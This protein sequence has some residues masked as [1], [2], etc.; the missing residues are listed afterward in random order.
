MAIKTVMRAWKCPKC[1]KL[2]MREEWANKCCQEYFCEVCGKSVPK[3][4]LKCAA[5]SEK[6]KF[7][8]AEKI[9]EQQWRDKYSNKFHMVSFDG[10]H[11]F[12][13]IESF[14]EDWAEEQYLDEG[15]D[16]TY[17]EH[18]WDTEEIP[19]IIDTGWIIEHTIE[20]S[21]YED[22][23]FDDVGVKELT[24]YINNWNKKYGKEGYSISYKTAIL[25][26]KEN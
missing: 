9:T 1:G 22:F 18:I 21:E 3:Y 12:D 24:D 20:N 14:K 25:L 4:R 6:A 19:I 10:E 8:K 15:E 5:C 26:D 17:P 7:E 13:S 23:E 16:V 2:Y 11:Y